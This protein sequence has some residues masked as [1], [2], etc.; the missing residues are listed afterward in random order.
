[1]S[2]VH[3]FHKSIEEQQA[4]SERIRR[5]DGGG[6]GGYD[7][8]MEARI[9]KLESLAEKTVDRLSSLE[10]D[11]AVIKSNY[12]TKADI[13]SAETSIIKWLVATAIAM[14]GLAFAA[15]KFIN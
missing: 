12:S 6:G 2:N 11:V 7:D 10:R 3:E 4:A 15:A 1:M 5:F 13:S 9:T 14:S 8:T